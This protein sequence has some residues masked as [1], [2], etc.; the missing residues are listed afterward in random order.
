MAG[1][2]RAVLA[3]RDA[4]GGLSISTVQSRQG[5]GQRRVLGAHQVDH[6]RQMTVKQTHAV[7][8]GPISIRLNGRQHATMLA[9]T[10]LAASP[11]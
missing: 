2:S 6:V 11:S 7:Q 5:E 1:D 3:A 10:Q 4:S 8:I 9:E